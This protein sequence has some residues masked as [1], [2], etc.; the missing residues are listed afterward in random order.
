MVFLVGVS[1]SGA[2]EQ[3]RLPREVPESATWGARE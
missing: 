3:R 1:A 2:R